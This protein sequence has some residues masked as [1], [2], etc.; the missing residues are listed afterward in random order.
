M[1]KAVGDSKGYSESKNTASEI[2]AR[3]RSRTSQGFFGSSSSSSNR[4]NVQ[5]EPSQ[6]SSSHKSRGGK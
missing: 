6:S 2:S 4:Q 1:K 5:V 3:Q